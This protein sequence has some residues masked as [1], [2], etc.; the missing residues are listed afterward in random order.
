MKA[1]SKEYK[2]R[3]IEQLADEAFE[4]LL[5]AD[6]LASCAW[7]GEQLFRDDVQT[8]RGSAPFARIAG[9]VLR[10]LKAQ[11]RATWTVD[12]TGWS[13]WKAIRPA[14]RKATIAEQVEQ[15]LRRGARIERRRFSRLYEV[16]GRTITQATIDE[17]LQAGTI[18]VGVRPGEATSAYVLADE[19]EGSR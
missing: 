12:G 8:M 9:K 5:K 6:R 2:R 19:D 4:L 16:G 7:V 10:K 18:V 3:T 11:G 14:K 15:L 1:V 13:G 17:L